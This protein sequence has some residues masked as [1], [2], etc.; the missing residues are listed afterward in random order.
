L[1]LL[2]RPLA[3]VLLLLIITGGSSIAEEGQWKTAFI[4]RGFVGSYDANLVGGLNSTLR[5]RTPLQFSGTKVR[6]YVRG[7]FEHEVELTRLALLQGA[8]D[9][10]K[11]T[12]QPFA[13]SFRGKEQLKLEKGLKEAVSDEVA[14]PVNRGTWYIE[15]Q[16]AS[17]KFPY[18]YDIDRG[19]YE[20]GQV[21]GKE[22]L[23]KSV[24]ARTGIAYRVDIFTTDSRGTILCFGDSI[25]HGYGSTPNVDR[26]YPTIL[27]KR[28]DRPVLN[29]GQNGD[30][31][32]SA[33]GLP[34][35][36]RGLP[37]VDTVV[38]LMGINDIY[39]GTNVNSAKIYGNA[40]QQLIAGCHQQHKKIYLG[41]IAPAGGVAKFDAD[42]AKERLRQEFNTWIRQGNG[43]DGVID[44]DAAL[45]DPDQPAKLKAD[46]Q[47]VWLHPNDHGYQLMAEA[48][49][50]VLADK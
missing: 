1:R 30:C 14:I 31:I 41:T 38:F 10:G 15:D 50:K 45:A 23:A 18:A 43:A 42:P 33:G 7:P 26:R 48:A 34:G 19:Y 36:V 13:I 12:G 16:H 32:M 4:K 6:I 8:N 2:G 24:G 20:A 3:A 35:T 44:F 5:M 29:M 17:Q 27:G 9:E 47:I 37:G 21:F 28:L 46:C 39:Q 40:I 49:A 11:V 22:T 25:T